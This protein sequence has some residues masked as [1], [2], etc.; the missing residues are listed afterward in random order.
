[1]PLVAMCVLSPSGAFTT[2]LLRHALATAVGQ[3]GAYIA[4]AGA[5]RGD[6]GRVIGCAA[7]LRWWLW[8]L[9]VDRPRLDL[10]L[11]R[12]GSKYAS[13]RGQDQG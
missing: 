13:C 1:M 3:L 11:A 9:A 7:Q 8:L 5:G 4:Q 10:G 2:A 6:R 12:A